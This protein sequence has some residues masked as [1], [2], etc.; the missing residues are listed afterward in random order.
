VDFF[1]NPI[2]HSQKFTCSKRWR[3]QTLLAISNDGQPPATVLDLEALKNRRRQ[4]AKSHEESVVLMEGDRAEDN[5]KRLLIKERN[6]FIKR[7]AE[8]ATTAALLQQSAKVGAAMLCF[9]D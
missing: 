8:P 2:E 7:P 3:T 4:A 1:N 6:P 5:V 9:A